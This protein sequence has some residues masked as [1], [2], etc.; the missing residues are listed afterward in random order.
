[1]SLES[2]LSR[3]EIKT[4]LSPTVLKEL[5][6]DLAIIEVPNKYIAS[7]LSDNCLDQIKKSFFEQLHY[8]PDIQFSAKGSKSVI[9]PTPHNPQK[10]LGNTFNTDLNQLLAFKNFVSYK[11]NR[12]ALSLALQLANNTAEYYTS[13][14]IFSKESLGKTHLLNAIGNQA[15][16]NNPSVKLIYVPLEKFST[17]YSLSKK[18]KNHRSFRE[19]YRELDVLLIDD[20]HRINGKEKLQKE[21]ISLIDHFYTSKKR[22]AF[23]GQLPPGQIRNL[24]PELRSRLEWG[25]L[26]EINTPDQK[27]RMKI[28]KK[29]AKAEKIAIPDDVIFFLASTMSDLKSLTNHLIRMESYSSLNQKPINLSTAKSFLKNSQR[30]KVDV[31]VIQKLTTDYFN[32]SK[33]DLL[34]DKKIHKY[35]YP[36]HVAMYLSRELTGLSFQEIGRAFG[37]KDHSTIIYAVKR[38]NKEMNQNK[39]IINDLNKLRKL[40]F[41]EK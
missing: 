19:R 21:T 18:N 9:D 11:R 24:L 33:R 27:T 30:K 38:I 36:R 2:S 5:D 17:E 12:F 15:I 26:S 6:K 3:S 22:I 13:L 39:E 28:I 10:K 25:L 16:Q 23:A 37:N 34:S 20:I 31:N 32:I 29:K 8:L 41:F 7:W 35:S 14:Y 40:L 1:M 4:W